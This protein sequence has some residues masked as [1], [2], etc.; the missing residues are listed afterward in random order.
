MGWIEKITIDNVPITQDNEITKQRKRNLWRLSDNEIGLELLF[1]NSLEDR[2]MDLGTLVLNEDGVSESAK[3]GF[4]STNIAEAL[5][6]LGSTSTLN[7]IKAFSEE[8]LYYREA[9]EKLRGNGISCPKHDKLAKLCDVV[10]TR[11]GI[12]LEEYRIIDR[13]FSP[14]RSSGAPGYTYYLNI[15]GIKF[16]IRSEIEELAVEIYQPKMEDWQDTGITA[17]QISTIREGVVIG[18]QINGSE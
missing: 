8:E 10:F 3:V 1:N 2:M 4:T 11:M 5:T 15:P 13:K 16:S 6:E 17:S 9:V 18:N 14:D 7:F 12:D